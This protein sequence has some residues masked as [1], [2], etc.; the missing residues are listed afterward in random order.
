[1]T[2]T[3]DFRLVDAIVA[4]IL[5]ASA[6]MMLQL[7]LGVFEPIYSL[8]LSLL[9]CGALGLAFV[10]GLR[11]PARL[12]A[13]APVLVLAVLALAPRW[14]PFL[15][16]EGGQ[17]Q[18]IYVAM[19]SHFA[20]THGIPVIDSVRERLSDNAKAD[21]DRLNNRYYAERVEVP[22]RFEGEH[23]PGIYIADLDRSRYVFQFYPLHPAWMAMA[24]AV[25]GGEHRVYALAT[26]RSWRS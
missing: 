20:R 10:R 6:V 9:L 7:V 16:V 19:S 12:A 5:V 21:Y 22:G 3:Q 8:F 25:L 1:M 17:D 11:M 2:R 18:G 15:Y 13:W 14:D 24:A 23:Q 4:F 26:P